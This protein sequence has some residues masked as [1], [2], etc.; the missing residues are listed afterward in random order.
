M[1]RKLAIRQVRGV[2]EPEPAIIEA[3]GVLEDSSIATL[4][5]NVFALKELSA[6]IRPFAVLS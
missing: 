5:M 4:R 1:K 2:S 6:A 3:T